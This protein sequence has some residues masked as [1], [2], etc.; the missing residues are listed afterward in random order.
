MHVAH[1]G[2]C[3]RNQGEIGP[4]DFVSLSEALGK[5][6]TEIEVPVHIW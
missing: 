3:R 6:Y 1:S 4:D 2:V 5:E